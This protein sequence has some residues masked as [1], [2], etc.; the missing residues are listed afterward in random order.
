MANELEEKIISQVE[1]YFGDINLP[2]DKFLKSKTEEDD[3]WVTI[4]VLLTFK[5]LANLSKDSEIIGNALKKSESGLLEVSEDNKKVRRNPEKQ[6]PEFNETRRRELSKRTAYAKGFPTD[7]ELPNILNFLEPYGPIESCIRRTLKKDSEVIFKGSCFIIFKD[8]DT[9]KKFIEAEEIKYKEV[10]LIRKWQEDYYASKKA[11]LD[12]LKKSRKEKKFAKQQEAHD[13][14]KQH[15]D[16]PKGTILFFDGI[17]E[18]KTITREEIK[19]KINEIEGVEIAFIDFNKG[20]TEGYLRLSK[21]N[22]APEFFKKLTDGELAV[23]EVKL[24]FKVLEGEEEENQLKK[25]ADAMIKIRKLQKQNSF[26]RKRRGHF[27]GNNA[28]RVKGSNGE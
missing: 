20:D 8:I 10:S 28:K 1:Y 14:E 26:N 22:S 9:C 21:E 16:I 25:T 27:K 24:K 5:R 12:E 18:G 7:E 3:G 19:D 6:I 17:E 13:K 23:G 15:I 4:E 11:E 2:R